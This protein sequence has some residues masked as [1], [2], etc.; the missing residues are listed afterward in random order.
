MDVSVKRQIESYPEVAVAALMQIRALVYEVA[1]E[2]G[3]EIEETLKW[4]QPSYLSQVGSTLRIDWSAKQ[5]E[6]YRVYFNCKTRL[7]ETF[8]EVF[9][10]VFKYESNRVI[11]FDLHESVPK[12]ELKR[13]I[14]MTLKYHQLKHLP[15]L[16]Q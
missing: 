6:K 1:D 5:P 8:K 13:C 7:V 9:G 4:G 2:Q 12:A 10:G 11:C 14:L 3:L 15:L 16:G